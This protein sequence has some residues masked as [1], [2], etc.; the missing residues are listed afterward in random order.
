MESAGDR[1]SNAPGEGEV[2]QPQG[3]GNPPILTGAERVEAA[4]AQFL[5]NQAAYMQWQTMQQAG[6]AATNVVDCFR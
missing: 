6:S 1:S 2:N 5:E 3:N 4:M